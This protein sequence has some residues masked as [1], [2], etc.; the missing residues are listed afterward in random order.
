M[1][2][3]KAGACPKVE[4]LE[5]GPGLTHNYYIR[6]GKLVR[7]KCSSLLQKF[8]TYG[9]KKFYNIGPRAYTVKILG[10][11][12]LGKTRDITRPGPIL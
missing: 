4:H 8:V 2:A 6:L 10:A 12:C 1:F 5:G 9:Y 11:L 7:I 3:G